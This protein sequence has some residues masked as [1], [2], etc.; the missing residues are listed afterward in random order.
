MRAPGNPFFLEGACPT[1]SWALQPQLLHFQILIH[2]PRECWPNSASTAPHGVC[3]VRAAR[4]PSS[5]PPPPPLSPVPSTPSCAPHT[6][7]HLSVSWVD[8][9]RQGGCLGKTPITHECKWEVRQHTAPGRNQSGKQSGVSS[10]TVPRSQ[11]T[12]RTLISSQNVFMN[13]IVGSFS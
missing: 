7:S 6:V 4:Q 3:S 2:S 1:S 13:C 9:A 11:S 8:V 12:V 5:P 10:V